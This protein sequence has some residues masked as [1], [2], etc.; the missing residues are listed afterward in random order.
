MAPEEEIQLVISFSEL[1]YYFDCPYQFKLRFL[2]GFRP[3]AS[4]EL[5]FGKSLHDA[6]AE[7]H[8]HA[9]AGTVLPTQEAPRLVADHLH[10]P[11]AYQKLRDDMAEKAETV[12]RRYLWDNRTR[13]LQTEFTEKTIELR[14]DN[15]LLVSGR[16]DLIRRLDTNETE[17]VDFKSTDRTQAEDVTR[18]Q[19]HVYAMGYRQLTGQDADLVSV[20]NLDQGA[21][22]TVRE[23]V[24]AAF[25]AQTQAAILDA[26]RAI[27]ANAF[28]RPTSCAGCDFAGI[29]RTR[30]RNMLEA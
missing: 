26:G 4:E 10:L 12:L 17:I 23:V 25:I 27:R 21:T 11:Y 22:G 2:Y 28:C 20:Y 5:G 1:R 14:L 9:M 15:G 18:T 3:G 30:P 16:I 24:D 6:L 19:L 8:R 7:I 29:C 13:L